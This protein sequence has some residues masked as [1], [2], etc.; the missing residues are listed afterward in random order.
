MQPPSDGGKAEG[1]PEK[2]V[3]SGLRFQDDFGS[4]NANQPEKIIGFR[5]LGRREGLPASMASRC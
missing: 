5:V 3:K 1:A 4:P 2:T